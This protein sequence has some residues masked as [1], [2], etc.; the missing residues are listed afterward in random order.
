M[1]LFVR[2]QD[3]LAK[4]S[5]NTYLSSDE[6]KAATILYKSIQTGK[7]PLNVELLLIVSLIL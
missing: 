6:R 2:E 5:R 1:F 7:E 4:S 3:G